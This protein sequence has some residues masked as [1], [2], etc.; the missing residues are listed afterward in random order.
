[1]TNQIVGP[2]A[3]RVAQL[4]ESMRRRMAEKAGNRAFAS[5]LA[6]S[7]PMLSIMGKEFSIRMPD[8]RKQ[9]IENEQGFAAQYLDVVLVDASTQL[10]KNY[11]ESGF[12]PKAKEFLPPDCWSL[13]AVKPDPSSAALQAGKTGPVCATCWANAF[14]SAITDTGKKAKA[15]QDHRRVVIMFP[16]QIGDDRVQ[17]LMMRVPQSSLKNLR[18]HA[19]HMDRYGLDVRAIVTR[20]SFATEPFPK[21]VFDYTEKV[22][23]EVQYDWVLELAESQMVKGMIATPDFDNT[24]SP[25]QDTMTRE[26]PRPQPVGTAPSGFSAP[27]GEEEENEEVVKVPPVLQRGPVET[28]QKPAETQQKPAETQ[29]ASNLMQLADGK[30]IDR[31]TGQYVEAPAPKAPPKEKVL[32]AGLMK[33]ADGKFVDMKTGHYIDDPYEEEAP[34]AEVQAEAP[35]PAPKRQRA[36]R[37]P[38]PEQQAAQAQAA[39]PEIIPPAAE[40]PADKPAVKNGNGSVTP[41]PAALDAVLKGLLNT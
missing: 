2:L 17:P 22:L 7:Y 37:K 16:H 23:D 33:L 18:G 19:D 28:Q 34:A 30:W 38:K 15:C 29:Q 36:P 9:R 20:M 32:K 13:D 25:E 21:L 27:V 10:A 4:P 39:E 6:A 8:G 41:A 14:G 35:A 31:D 1:M 12:D 40:K 24:V 11:Y 26:K 5:N 3:N